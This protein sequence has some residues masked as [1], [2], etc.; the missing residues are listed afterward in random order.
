MSQGEVLRSGR[1]EHPHGTRTAHLRERGVVFFRDTHLADLR[2]FL[3]EW[4]SPYVHPHETQPG[5]TL[6]EPRGA[7]GRGE[8]GFSRE[9]MGLHTDRATSRTPPSIVALL[10]LQSPRS[11]GEALL[12]DGAE[13]L[14]SI[15]DI[16]TRDAKNDF[17]LGA[18]SR[19][20]FPVCEEAGGRGFVRIRYRCDDIARPVALGKASGRALD[21]IE[22]L[23]RARRFP[24]PLGTG[25]IIH[26]HRYLHGRTRFEGGRSIA[27]ILADVDPGFS[28]S[29]LNTGFR[30]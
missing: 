25:C 24:L 4:T 15:P 26:N 7:T 3:T 19:V 20:L 9:D 18:G 23:R 2:H 22:N 27:R 14:R 1:S 17:F 28:L 13:L 29:W 5:L 10:V 6:I 30:Y 11:G 8:D 12:M 16:G 21:D